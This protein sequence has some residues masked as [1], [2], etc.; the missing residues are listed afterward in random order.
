MRRLSVFRKRDGKDLPENSICINML[1]LL[2][3][4]QRR[5]IGALAMAHVRDYCRAL[6]CDC[7]Y[8]GCNMHNENAMRFYR[9]KGGRMI[10][11]Y[12]G[13]KDRGLDQ[14]V[15]EHLV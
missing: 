4:Y 6:S 14:A 7:F 12:G 1:Y 5:G 9:A 2:R 11:E 15:F 10:A 3:A 13:H 8:N